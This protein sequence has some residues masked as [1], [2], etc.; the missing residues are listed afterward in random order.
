MGQRLPRPCLRAP[1]CRYLAGQCPDHPV[2]AARWDVARQT[3]GEPRLRG[4]ALVQA[5]RALFAREPLCRICTAAGRMA[6]ATIRDHIVPLA[7][8]GR[9]AAE[10][11]QALC[12]RCSDT[13]TAGEAA[14]AWSSRRP[15]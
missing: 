7:E 9:E 11:T 14:R 1:R 5:R 6:R 13:K 15:V 10:N 4:W 12:K 8:G 2:P 3:A